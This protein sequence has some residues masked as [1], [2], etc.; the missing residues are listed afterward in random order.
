LKLS[1]K[2]RQRSN[3]T[4]KRAPSCRSGTPQGLWTWSIIAKET[5]GEK[6]NPSLS[7]VERE[8]RGSRVR[9]AP[10]R[11]PGEEQKD[12]SVIGTWPAFAFMWTPCI[13][14]KFRFQVSQTG[15]VIVKYVYNEKMSTRR[16]FF[17]TKI[18]LARNFEMRP[19]TKQT[20]VAKRVNES[21]VVFTLNSL[22]RFFVL[23]N[24]RS[25]CDLWKIFAKRV[26][27]SVSFWRNAAPLRYP[28]A[29]IISQVGDNFHCREA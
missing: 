23:D 8:S 19:I 1:S 20:S 10:L 26:R 24:R 15:N 29:V 7:A 18:V 17:F 3:F 16:L 11:H 2:N 14:E 28:T 21:G 13:Q 22:K 12:A 6:V 25:R 9:R 27:K 4:A 5:S